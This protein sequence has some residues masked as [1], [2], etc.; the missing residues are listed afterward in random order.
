MAASDQPHYNCLGLMATS[1]LL[2]DTSLR[3]EIEQFQALLD[4]ESLLQHEV[5][6]RNPHT[7]QIESADPRMSEVARDEKIKVKVCISAIVVQW[8]SACC[9]TLVCN[10]GAHAH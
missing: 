6:L 1:Y 8:E 4:R 10:N 7:L 2:L 3:P 9:F 5:I